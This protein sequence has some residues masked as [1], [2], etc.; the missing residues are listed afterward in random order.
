M[1]KFLTFPTNPNIDPTNYYWFKDAFSSEE[2][3]SLD[4]LQK[5]YDFQ[6]AVTGKNSDS[7][8]T[9]M[10]K[11]QIKWLHHSENS[12][13][14]YNKIEAMIVEANQIWGFDLHSIRDSIQYTEYYEGGGHYDW[15]MDVGPFPMNGRK[16]SI[17]IQLSSPDEYEGGNFE[18]RTTNGIQTCVKEKGTVILFPSYLLHRITPV[19][20][21]TRKSIVLWVGGSTYR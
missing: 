8:D 6:T 5:S 15:H 16:I 17:T 18:I 11:S 10:R 13:W 21:G 7:S 1:N 19:T 12:D 20:S 4:I 2:Y 9:K 3:K 14:L